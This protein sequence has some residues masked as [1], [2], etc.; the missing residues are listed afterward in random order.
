MTRPSKQEERRSMCPRKLKP[1]FAK[2]TGPKQD[3]LS[4]GY[5]ALE[6]SVKNNQ[7]FIA[8]VK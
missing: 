5:K 2:K 1:S 8:K 3:N 6:N 7:V 4:L